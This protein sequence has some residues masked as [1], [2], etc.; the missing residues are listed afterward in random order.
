MR[1]LQAVVLA[2]STLSATPALAA[3]SKEEMVKMLA[4]IDDR[5]SNN[6]DFKMRF[7]L[8]SKERD[9]TDTVYEGFVYRRDADDKLMIL[10]DKPKTEAGKG[11]LRVDKNLWMYD[12]KVGKWERRTERER[13]GGTNSRRSDF[14]ESRLAQEFDPSFLGEEKLGQ[15]NA[16]KLEL[17]AK[18]GVD[19]AFPVV[20]LW[21]D[22]DAGNVLKRQD[23]ALSGRLMRT[24][25]YPKWIKQ[26]SETKKADVWHPKEM[27]FYD[28]VDKANQ[29]LILV[30][31]VDLHALDQNLFTKA[32]LESKSR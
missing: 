6:G 14:D 27:R 23:F 7:Y 5:Q 17:K 32:W 21:I 2:V 28:E 8:E 22:K 13:I 16:Y 25:Y 12:P 19:V 24:D 26:Y 30:Q 20:H 31:Q 15:Y 18:E 29:T 11:Y 10:F 3:L 4:T 9:K 1:I